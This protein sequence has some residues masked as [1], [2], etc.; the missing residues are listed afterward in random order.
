MRA[1]PMAH[2]SPAKIRMTRINHYSH[3]CSALLLASV[4]S[5]VNLGNPTMR[6]EQAALLSHD[7]Q[8]L[9]PNVSAQEA[10]KMASTAIEQSIR[11][12]EDYKPI[13]VAWLNNSLVNIGLRDRGLC[14]HWRNDLFPPLYELESKTLKL[15]LA[16]SSRGNYF[17]HNAIVV[18]ATD[19][20]FEQ[21]LILDPWRK[22]G[23]LWWG[24]FDE[25]KYP[26]VLL[27]HKQT[28]VA[29]RPM[30]SPTSADSE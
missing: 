14:Y 18:T 4:A 24:H 6:A 21:G 12:S 7:L 19:T 30:L 1:K 26:W 10:D 23:R 25:D 27:D 13:R 15:R 17:E 29:L 11:I 16:T 8:Q 28:P 22:G 9:S 2:P 20:A 3:L 5:C